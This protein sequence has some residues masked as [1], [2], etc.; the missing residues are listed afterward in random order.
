MIVTPQQVEA[1]RRS[2]AEYG[3]IEEA[4][5]VLEQR[6]EAAKRRGFGWTVDQL[7]HLLVALLVMERKLN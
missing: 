4:R 7:N 2:V 6:R 3:G 5:T 1:A